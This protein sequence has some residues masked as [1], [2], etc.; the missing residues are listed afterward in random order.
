ML[1]IDKAIH[2]LYEELPRLV[3]EKPYGENGRFITYYA[4]EGLF[5]VYDLWTHG[6]YL[7]EGH[8]AEDAIDNVCC[9]KLS[10]LPKEEN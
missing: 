1:N 3:C 7:A 4:A 10:Y 8:S 9:N 6:F 5:L 2:E